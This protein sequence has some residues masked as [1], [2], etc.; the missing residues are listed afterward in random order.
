MID[1]NQTFTHG[2]ADIAGVAK[3]NGV[4]AISFPTCGMCRVLAALSFYFY[5]ICYAIS[6]LVLD[7]NII[8]TPAPDAPMH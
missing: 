8:D 7:P 2:L 3:T 4:S 6:V 5:A 1:A